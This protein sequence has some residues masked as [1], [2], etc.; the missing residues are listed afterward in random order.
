M[1]LNL[2]YPHVS[3]AHAVHL[4]AYLS[5][6]GLHGEISFRPHPDEPGKVRIQTTLEATLQY[7]DQ[8]WN[9]ALHQLPVDYSDMDAFRRCSD[10]RIGKQLINLDEKLGLLTMSGNESVQW[11]TDFALSGKMQLLHF[12]LYV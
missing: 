10:D 6:H 9:W 5:Q 4:I 3:V 7:P 12:Y 11:D 2:N 8:S 1:F